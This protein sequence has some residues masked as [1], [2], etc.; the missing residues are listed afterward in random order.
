MQKSMGKF[1]KLVLTF[2]FAK[3]D[4]YLM[5]HLYL[6]GIKI[7]DTCPLA[8]YMCSR[9]DKNSAHKVYP[10]SVSTQLTSPQCIIFKEMLYD[11]L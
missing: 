5:S 9:D 3:A 10:L 1:Q 8:F 11:A 4:L 6:T 2:Y 7:T